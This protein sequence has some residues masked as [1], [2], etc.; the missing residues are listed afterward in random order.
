MSG[1]VPGTGADCIRSRQYAVHNR[2]LGCKVEAIERGIKMAVTINADECI[3]CGVC[4]D[5]CPNEAL[6]VDGVCTV[7][8]DACIDCGSCVDECPVEAISA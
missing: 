6:T 4:V 2:Q 8:A 1:G 5:A 7:D 3:G